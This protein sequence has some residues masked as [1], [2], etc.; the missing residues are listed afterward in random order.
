MLNI[1]LIYSV[2]ATS[3]TDFGT[4][5][6]NCVC[7]VTD[8]TPSALIL[9]GIVYCE[10]VTAHSRTRTHSC[11]LILSES[12]I[13][14]PDFLERSHTKSAYTNKMLATFLASDFDLKTASVVSTVILFIEIK[15]DLTFEM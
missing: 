7:R 6:V 12:K 1:K 2:W 11:R 15:E 10:G 13:S 8:L 14:V 3:V 4:V 9:S 5:G